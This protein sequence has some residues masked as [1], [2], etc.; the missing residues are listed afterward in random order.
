MCLAIELTYRI[1][2]YVNIGDVNRACADIV[3][4]EEK[5]PEHAKWLLA[6]LETGDDW[7]HPWGPA[8]DAATGRAVVAAMKAKKMNNSK[9]GSI[10]AIQ[11]LF[12]AGIYNTRVTANYCNSR[13]GHTVMLSLFCI[14]VKVPWPLSQ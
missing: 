2:S 9:A 13:K 12:V 8:P 10:I 14:D 6:T 3:V 1:G 7:G 4:L 11:S 5:N